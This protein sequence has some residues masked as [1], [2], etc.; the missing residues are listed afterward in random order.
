MVFW[1][2]AIG[3]ITPARRF[4][5]I[6][7]LPLCSGFA[8]GCF[9]G[10]FRVSGPLGT[11][12][13]AATG[14]FAVWLVSYYLLARL[15]VSPQ[16]P[17]PVPATSSFEVID[18]TTTFD[19]TAWRPVTEA[20]RRTKTSPATITTILTVRRLRD[21]M[22]WYPHRIASTSLLEP[23]YASTTHSIKMDPAL[24][25]GVTEN[26]K[27]WWLEVD[28]SR[29]PLYD[30]FIIEYSYKTWNGFQ[31]ISNEWAAFCSSHPTRHL[32]LVVKLPP[33]KPLRSYELLRYPRVPKAKRELYNGPR[34]VT[35]NSD[36]TQITWR[37]DSPWIEYVHRINWTW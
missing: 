2:F 34:N 20:Q 36:S 14:G 23:E 8:C 1:A 5:L 25:P 10:S 16:P 33:T 4:L 7:L 37:I 32:Q 12:A 21:D 6:W 24:D 22:T 15:D 11:L 26:M 31:G 9:A 30:P 17:K 18:N 35:I 29:E 28:V 19:V 27:A 3:D 13:I